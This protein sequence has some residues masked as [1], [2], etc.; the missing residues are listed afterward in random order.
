M[1]VNYS[2]LD[3]DVKDEFGKRRFND[4]AKYVFN[5]GF[6]Q[7]L[8]TWAAAFGATYRK[9]GQAFGRVVGE[10][11][12]TTY[13][14]DL[15]IFIEKRF[16][17]RYVVRLT[18]TNLLDSKKKETFNK[19]TTIGDQISRDFDEYELEREEAGPVFQLVARAT[20]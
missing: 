19:F 15:E 8:P 14:A 4:Q 2:W 13:G 1:F 17:D 5:V 7:D 6:I 16:G 11:V 20:F 3:S 18:G 10:E 9:Q 12:T